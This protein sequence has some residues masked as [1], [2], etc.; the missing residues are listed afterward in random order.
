MDQFKTDSL[1][2]L[3]G[4]WFIISAWYVMTYRWQQ[5]FDAADEYWWA[6]YVPVYRTI[7]ALRTVGVSAWWTIGIFM[8]YWFWL[9]S[10]RMPFKVGSAEM[11]MI[12]LIGLLPVV[13]LQVALWNKQRS[14]LSGV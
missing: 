9:V 11:G 12:G 5:A 10:F 6:V 8:W 13:L 14:R 3:S 1:L 4:W 2:F 7:C